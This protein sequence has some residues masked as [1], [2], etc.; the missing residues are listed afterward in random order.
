MTV[1]HQCLQYTAECQYQSVSDP[2]DI[3]S[4]TYLSSLRQPHAEECQ[5]GQRN[6]DFHAVRRGRC[7]GINNQNHLLIN[8]AWAPHGAR[9]ENAKR[10]NADAE[11]QASCRKTRTRN[12]HSIVI[13]HALAAVH[14]RLRAVRSRVFQ[15]YAR[16][17][18]CFISFCLTGSLAQKPQ[19][20]IRRLFVFSDLSPAVI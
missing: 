14:T 6:S 15:H 20:S 4:T 17:V 11:R 10:I 2:T 9:T 1:G 12:H 7:A 16:N 8:C 19:A 3:I 5:Y 18:G 13:R